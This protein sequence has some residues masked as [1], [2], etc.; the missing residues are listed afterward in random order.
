MF[1]VIF[2]FAAQVKYAA[3]DGNI[4]TVTFIKGYLFT[5]FTLIED[6]FLLTT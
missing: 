5:Y 2:Q 1:Y 3:L 6:F 4:A